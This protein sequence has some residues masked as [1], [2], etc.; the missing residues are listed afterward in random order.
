MPIRS[1]AIRLFVSSTFSDFGLERQILDA[2]IF[3]ELQRYCFDRGFEFQPVDLRWGISD[4]IATSQRTLRVCLNEVNECV[5]TTLRPY[6]L[7]LVGD[8]YGWRPLPEFIAQDEFEEL[9]QWMVSDRN[10][11]ASLR[12]TEKLLRHWYRLD[13]NHVPPRFVLQPRSSKTKKARADWKQLEQRL[14]VALEATALECG[15]TNEAMDKYRLSATA[16]EIH[17]GVVLAST[18]A[19]VDFNKHVL[20]FHRKRLGTPPSEPLLANP[21]Y[22]DVTDDGKSDQDA[23]AHPGLALRH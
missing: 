2:K 9:T 23:A 7:I 1:T 17:R 21:V 11:S 4:D 3:P 20:C 16:Q 6:F 5:K 8:R 19:R 13:L 15:L 12:A 14:R 10:G 22:V 18:Q